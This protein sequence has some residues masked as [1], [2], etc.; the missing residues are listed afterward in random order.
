MSDHGLITVSTPREIL[1]VAEISAALTQSLWLHL[2]Q[3]NEKVKNFLTRSTC[4]SC[5]IHLPGQT[6]LTMR[7]RTTFWPCR[8]LLWI[9]WFAA[10][11]KTMKSSFWNQEASNG[12]Q[13]AE[14]RPP[15]GKDIFC[16]LQ[17]N[18]LL[19]WIVTKC[20]H[21]AKHFNTRLALQCLSRNSC[22]FNNGSLN[23]ICLWSSVS[24]VQF[25]L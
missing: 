11:L 7:L 10:I 25:F 3:E 8:C 19:H 22:L 23:T 20:H 9:S 14:F 24:S 5:C 16:I 17:C 21:L 18:A 15:P 13:G 2:L 12:V 4:I 6:E 1:E